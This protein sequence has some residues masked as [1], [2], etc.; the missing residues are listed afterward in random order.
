LTLLVQI[1]SCRA[2]PALALTL[3]SLPV[4]EERAKLV[5]EAEGAKQERSAYHKTLTLTLTLILTLTLT[6]N[7]NP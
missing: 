7:P 5:E 4:Q 3:T 2:N 1:L 6:P